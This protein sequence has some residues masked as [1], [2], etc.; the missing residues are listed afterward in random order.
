MYVASVIQPGLTQL[1]EEGELRGL[2]EHALHTRDTSNDHRGVGGVV[3]EVQGC[4]IKHVF[5]DGIEINKLTPTTF[6]I[7]I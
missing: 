5:D 7:Y 2:L 4:E 3:L 6:K 1:A